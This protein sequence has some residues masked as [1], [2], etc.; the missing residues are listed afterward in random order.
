[1]SVYLEKFVLVDR[2]EEE[3]IVAE[4][5]VENGGVKLGY[6]DNTYPCGLF[7]SKEL[8]ELDFENI[9]I[10][11]GGN[12]SG[13]STLLNLISSKLKLKRISPYNS[14]EMYDKYMTKCCYRL[15]YD[16]YGEPCDI[17]SNSRI[18]TS[19]DVFDYML[20]V[21]D[22]NQDINS[23]IAIA[24]QDWADKRYGDTIKLNSMDDYEDF[25]LQV[26]ARSKMSRRKFAQNLVGKQI[27]LNSNGETAFNYFK[28]KLKDNTLYCLDEPEN[29]L[30]PK[31]QLELVKLIEDMARYFGCQFI[32][33]T[34]SPFLLA[35]RGAKIYDLDTTPVEIKK[36]WELENT[37]TY[38][39]FFNQHRDLFLN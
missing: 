19:D 36:W 21:R 6:V 15:G 12:G 23:N 17:P 10:L 31:I 39:D 11:Y 7:S 4:K 9:T 5:M 18:V 32:I 38:F 35:I 20:N 27:K 37:K 29:S 3:E 14:S 30:S 26:M 13:K 1:M 24:K 28:T 8:K 22:N 2:E 33:A 34:H 25:R 16:D